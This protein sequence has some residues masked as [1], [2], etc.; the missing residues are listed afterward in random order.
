MAGSYYKELYDA[1]MHTTWVTKDKETGWNL[2]S[3]LA[4]Q[5]YG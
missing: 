4:N 2:I 1:C 3:G 5:N